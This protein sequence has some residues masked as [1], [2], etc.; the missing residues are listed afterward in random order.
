MNDKL[1]FVAKTTTSGE[2]L[3]Y[4]KTELPIYLNVSQTQNDDEK[5]K[6]VLYPNPASLFIKIKEN[7]TSEVETYKVFDMTGKQILIGKYKE[8]NQSINISKLTSGN[9]I[10]E[11][12]TKSGNR[13]SQKFIKK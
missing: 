4:V 8:E 6:L 9:Y 2:E 10:I 12:T 11:I 5:F 1:Y 13:F 7:A 3:Y